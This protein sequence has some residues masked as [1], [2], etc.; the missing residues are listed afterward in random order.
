MK[1]N[2]EHTPLLLLVFG[3]SLCEMAYISEEDGL[4]LESQVRTMNKPSIMTFTVV[5]I[6]DYMTENIKYGGGGGT[7][8]YNLTVAHDQFSTHNVWIETGPQDHISMIAAGWMVSPR[9]YGD[10]LPRVFTYWTGD[11]YRNG[12]YDALC[13]GFVQVDREISPGYPI[14]STSTYGGAQSVLVV[15]IEQDRN[16][17][18]W[19]LILT[20]R[21]IKIG[22]WPKELFLY[23]RNGSLHT[24]WGGVGVAGSDGV[25]PPM[26]SGHRPDEKAT[27][28]ALEVQEVIAGDRKT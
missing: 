18:N 11:G 2:V 4:D 27:S 23:L 14:Y 19:W 6:T 26:G 8:V 13:P 3:L 9:L 17:G 15:H 25:C 22:Y 12:C 10:N 7:T 16:T 1:L 20:S 28:L 24:A 5:S 21:A